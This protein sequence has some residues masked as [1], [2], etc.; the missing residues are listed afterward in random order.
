MGLE[1]VQ[2]QLAMT[3][4][5]EPVLWPKQTICEFSFFISFSSSILGIMDVTLLDDKG[6]LARRIT[7]FGYLPRLPP[8]SLH[9]LNQASQPRLLRNVAVFAVSAHH[10][11]SETRS[12]GKPASSFAHERHLETFDVSPFHPI[13]PARHARQDDTQCTCPA[14]TRQKERTCSAATCAAFR[15]NAT[16]VPSGSTKREGPSIS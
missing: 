15:E 1:A 6:I 8:P 4:P 16:P 13:L 11:P 2:E 9:L 5:E 14:H 12:L 3:R 10:L 7:S